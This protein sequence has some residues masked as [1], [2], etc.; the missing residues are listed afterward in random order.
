MVATHVRKKVRPLALLP[1][2]TPS[3]LQVYLSVAFCISQK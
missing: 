2:Q 3:P 1:I